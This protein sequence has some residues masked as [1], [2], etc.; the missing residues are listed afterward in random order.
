MLRAVSGDGAPSEAAGA[1]AYVRVDLPLETAALPRWAEALELARSMAGE[2]LPI[3][4]C[5]EAIAA[6]T[7]AAIGPMAA[8]EPG[9]AAAADAPRLRQR[10]HSPRGADGDP[11]E[12]GLRHAAFPTLR[13][14]AP[15]ALRAARDLEALETWATDASPHALDTALRDGVHALQHLDHDLGALLKEIQ[16]RRLH[17]EL[18]FARFD[19]YVE[20]R[21]DVAPRT[22][23]RWIRIARLGGPLGVVATAF[24]TGALTEMQAALVGKVCAPQ[25]APVWVGLARQ[26]TLRRLEAEVAAAAPST[27]RVSFLAPPEVAA[28]FRAALATVRTQLG[29]AAGRPAR[30]ARA[31]TWMLDH[32]IASWLEQGAAFD[33]YADFTRDGFRCTAPGCTARRNLHSHHI[34]FRSARGPD[35][36]WNR[37]TLCA[38]HHQR[39]VH[40]G[41]V[42]CHGRAPEALVFSLGIRPEGAALLRA[43]SGDRLMP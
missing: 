37:T 40:A 26:V 41:V 15:R 43:R 10:P 5:A 19:R 11:N 21:V 28:V 3:W 35:E 25:S 17:H 23:R 20:E 24:R 34:V 13:F 32:A 29:D 14:G 18:G 2:A 7:L 9:R 39:G 6:E 12:P 22:A 42:A 8:R 27:Q 33:D 16:D 1:A 36:P 31:L 30:P 4:E 38:F